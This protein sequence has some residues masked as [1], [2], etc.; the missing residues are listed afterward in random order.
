[1]NMTA[2]DNAKSAAEGSSYPINGTYDIAVFVALS[3]C[4]VVIALI[5]FYKRSR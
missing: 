1:M 3:V 4:A 2:I 5:V